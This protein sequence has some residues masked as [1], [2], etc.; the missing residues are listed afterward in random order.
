MYNEKWIKSR[1]REEENI[2]IG[3]FESDPKCD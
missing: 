1:S 3:I 2:R